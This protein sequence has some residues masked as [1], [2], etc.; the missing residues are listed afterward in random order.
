ME[1]IVEGAEEEDFKSLSVGSDKFENKFK[2]PI[3]LSHSLSDT[4]YKTKNCLLIRTRFFLIF[5][6]IILF[7]ERP[8]RNSFLFYCTHS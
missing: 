4:Q 7:S 5:R 2:K 8:V 6:Q 3:D 1:I